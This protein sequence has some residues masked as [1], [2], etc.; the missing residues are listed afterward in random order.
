MRTAALIG[1]AQTGIRV[2]ALLALAAALVSA[3]GAA[4]ASAPAEPVDI[5]I[6][7]DTTGSMGSSIRQAQDDARRLVSGVRTFAPGSRFAIVQFRDKGDTPEYEVVQ[8]MTADAT[9]IEAALDKLS[10]GG[11]GDTPEAY[12]LVFRNSLD[13]ALGW[14]ASARKIVVVIGDAEPHGAAAAGF[15]KCSDRSADP[16]GLNTATELQRMRAGQRTLLMVL[17]K[18]TARASLAC[19]KQLAEASHTGGDARQ[20]GDNLIPVIQTLIKKALAGAYKFSFSAYGNPQRPFPGYVGDFQLGPVRISGSGTASATSGK[21]GVSLSFTP[22]AGRYRAISTTWRIVRL[23]SATASGAGTQLR[24]QVRVAS[25]SIPEI[26]PAGT[27]GVLTLVE[28]ATK[29][30]NGFPSHSVQTF[31][32]SP[33][34]RAPDGGLACR[35]HV[36]GMNNTDVSWSDPPRGGYPSGGNWARVDLTP[37]V[38][39]P[40][41]TTTTGKGPQ[42]AQQALNVIKA[43]ITK[44][45]SACGITRW[46][47][48]VSGTPGRWTASVEVTLPSGAGLAT[49]N[50][51]GA[52]VTPSNQLAAE[53]AAGCP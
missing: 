33:T 45:T 38:A 13:A 42:T 6:A 7:I 5:E 37:I 28:D 3:T 41:T 24:I 49:W 23:L 14:R 31:F 47:I 26:C 36:H 53:I 10:A 30:A 43:I 40:P 29:L 51:V 22:K 17:Q 50:I 39:T 52:T 4:S 1:R 8:P 44:N 9:L 19:Y 18:A 11:G 21:G 20:S 25:H 46:R 27:L 12:N 34:S 35:T 48:S 15:D 2:G 32:P 16:G